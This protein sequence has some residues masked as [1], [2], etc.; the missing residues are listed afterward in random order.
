MNQIT[1]RFDPFEP[2]INNFQVVD[3]Q[4]LAEIVASVPNLPTWFFALGRVAINGI[5]ISRENWRVVRPNPGTLITL[6][7]PR[8]MGGGGV[9]NVLSIVATIA[10]IALAAAVSGGLLGPAGLGWFG[11]SFAAGGLGAALAGTAIGIVGQLAITALT[12][13]AQQSD[14]SNGSLGGTKALAGVNGNALQPLDVLPAVLGKMRVS[15]PLLIKPFTTLENGS[16]FT[17]AII[18]MPGEYD[19]ASIRVNNTPITDLPGVEYQ[20]RAGAS[21]DTAL[22]L[23]TRT[24]IE[25]SQ[26]IQ[27]SEVDV[28]RDTVN[29]VNQASPS[30]SMPTWHH[31][32]SA[33]TPEEIVIRLAWFGGLSYQGTAAARSYF[34]LQIRREGSNTWISLPTLGFEVKSLRQERQTIKLKF[35][36]STSAYAAVMPVTS[37]RMAKVAAYESVTGTF[38]HQTHSYFNPGV[39]LESTCK[40]VRQDGDDG[41]IIYLAR[42]TFQ[43]GTYEVRIQ[44]GVLALPSALLPVNRYFE[45]QLSG[46]TNVIYQN[47]TDLTGQAQLESFSTVRE[48]YP[49]GFTKDFALIAICGR[50]IAI[51]SI[52]AEFTSKVPIYS[53]GNWNTT[54][55]SRNPAALYRYVLRGSLNA[56]PLSADLVDDTNLQTWYAHCVT[57]GY[58]CDAIVKGLSVSNVLRMI[59]AAGWSVP[60]QSDKWGV[61]TEKLRSAEPIVQNF[62]PLNTMGF[63]VSK[64]FPKL[65]HAL[66]CEFYNDADDYEISD[67]TVYA[68]GYSRQT[69]TLIESITYDGITKKSDV[70]KRALLDLRQMYLRPV[71][72][73]LNCGPENIVSRRGDLVGLTHDVIDRQ[74]AYGIIKSVTTSGPDITGLVMEATVDFTFNDADFF[75]PA[76]FFSPQTDI[77]ELGTAGASIRGRTG[78]I[79]TVAISN[80]TVTDTVTFASPYEDEAGEIVAGNLVVFGIISREFRRCLIFSIEADQDLTAQITLIDEAP[81]I[82]A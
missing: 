30:T 15:P 2:V 60:R 70:E 36:P 42:Q 35:L 47:Q 25:D 74:H 49:L 46:S 24:Q 53:G 3:G 9:K 78:D 18:G 12:P 37:T 16:T 58:N 61:I 45:Y 7:P 59:A 10:V 68:D 57:K 52:N 51:Q 33:G 50:D 31:W 1:T 80:T 13:P 81:G 72:Y 38:A 32:R 48:D 28:D 6:Y 20:T 40:Y 82:H 23:I 5:E 11:A 17:H 77:F 19:I 21:S 66:R 65:P 79:I 14:A 69:A 73:K 8:M 41:F 34:R 29:L 75:A 63:T 56:N 62:T 4:T 71:K 39:G 76:D 22:T 27:F 55:A 67:T 43:N 44:R 54:A 64:D 26:N